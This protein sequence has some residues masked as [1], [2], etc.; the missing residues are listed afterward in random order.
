MFGHAANPIFFNKKMAGSP[1]HSL[2]SIPLRPKTSH[3]C[4][5]PNPLLL[6]WTSFVYHPLLK[7]VSP[8]KILYFASAFRHSKIVLFERGR[9]WAVLIPRQ[10]VGIISEYYRCTENRPCISKISDQSKCFIFR[11]NPL[12]NN[13]PRFS[14]PKLCRSS[15]YVITILKFSGRPAQNL[16]NFLK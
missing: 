14:L 12:K 9:S 8:Y 7:K 5:T 10:F 13:W 2:L 15:I 3:F 16:F 1:E 4:L 6:K 11:H